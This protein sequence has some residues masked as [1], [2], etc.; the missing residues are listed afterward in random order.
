MSDR[1]ERLRKVARDREAGLD[2]LREAQ[3]GR[4]EP[5][6][7]TDAELVELG[8]LVID[9]GILFSD[10]DG[11]PTSASFEI[12]SWASEGLGGVLSKFRTKVRV[13][14]DGEVRCGKC[15]GAL[16]GCGWF[17]TD[18]R[19]GPYCEKCAGELNAGRFVRWSG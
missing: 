19:S 1:A 12:P 7:P 14:D 8:D 13:D 17:S 16:P 9:Q 3:A 2:G 18:D 5:A 4:G 6:E 10:K 11:T 15:K